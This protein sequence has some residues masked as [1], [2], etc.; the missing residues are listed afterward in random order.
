MQFDWYTKRAGVASI[1]AATQFYMITDNSEGFRDT[2]RFLSDR[3]DEA[4]GA[5]DA[6]SALLNNALLFAKVMV[7]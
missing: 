4:A 5:H 1:F 3:V 6:I 7:K 2:W